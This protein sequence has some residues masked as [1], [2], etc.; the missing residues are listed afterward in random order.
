MP[1]RASTASSPSPRRSRHASGAIGLLGPSASRALGRLCPKRSLAGTTPPAEGPT[2]AVVETV[3]RR[4]QGI[5]GLRFTER[6]PVHAV[7]REELVRGI[8]QTFDTQYPTRYYAAKSRAWAAIGAIPPGTEIRDQIE[9]FSSTQVIGYYDE[10]S[11]YLVYIGSNH[12]SPAEAVTLAHE[13]THA[14]DDQHFGL[15]P[16]DQLTAECDDESFGPRSRSPRATR[17]T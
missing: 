9:R 14:L 4:V 6:V 7:T 17:R 3:E 11:K 8:S 16:L 13:L 2:P 5:R 15:L 12:P 10:V 1:V